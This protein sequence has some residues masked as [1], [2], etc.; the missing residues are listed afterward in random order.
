MREGT[1][2]K[3]IAVLNAARDPTLKHEISPLLCDVDLDVRV[4]HVDVVGPHHRPVTTVVRRPEDV[5][6]G[7][8]V[9][10]VAEQAERAFQGC[11]SAENAGHCGLGHG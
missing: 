1:M 2:G 4:H 8:L 11:P 3:A 6:R 7:L 10:E 9:A 5:G